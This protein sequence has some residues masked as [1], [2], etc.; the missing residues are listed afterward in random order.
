MLDRSKCKEML[1][2]DD[3]GET[4]KEMRIVVEVF[5]KGCL[6]VEKACTWS[7]AE[8][9]KSFK[10]DKSIHLE[11]WDNCEEIKEPKKRLMARDEVLEF[12]LEN[13]KI[14]VE[15]CGDIRLPHYWEYEDDIE[16]FSYC[17][18]GTDEWLKFEVEE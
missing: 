6:A 16:L 14:L 7:F 3:R 1:V 8:Y 4:A 12:I 17:R 18:L 10:E 9:R 5:N 13:P 11:Y 2:W 15:Y